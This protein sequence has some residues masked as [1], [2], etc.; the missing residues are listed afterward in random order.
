MFFLCVSVS[1]GIG[2]IWASWVWSSSTLDTFL[3]S[4]FELQAVLFMKVR[5]HENHSE[6]A[7]TWHFPQEVWYSYDI[8]PR[9]WRLDILTYFKAPLFLSWASVIKVLSR[10]TLQ[11]WRWS[12]AII[13]IMWGA[14]CAAQGWNS[15]VNW[16]EAHSSV[17]R[18]NGFEWRRYAMCAMRYPVQASFVPPGGSKSQI[19]QEIRRDICPS[20]GGTILFLWTNNDKQWQWKTIG[21]IYVTDFH[22]ECLLPRAANPFVPAQ[23]AWARRSWKSLSHWQAVTDRLKWLKWLISRDFRQSL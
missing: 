12:F 10:N 18:C 13:S 15:H 5:L 8:L 6:H 2:H 3:C 16:F 4:D 11:P 23:H 20:E 22:K 21:I 17:P 7:E 1:T 9:F 14:G 19:Q